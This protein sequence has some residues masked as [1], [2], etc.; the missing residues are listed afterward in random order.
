MI[1]AEFSRTISAS[2]H[3]K[4][5]DGRG[6]PCFSS[7]HVLVC[8][9]EETRWRAKTIDRVENIAFFFFFLI[10]TVRQPTLLCY[11]WIFNAFRGVW[12]L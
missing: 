9:H 3:G 8:L 5:D 2:A 4:N 1:V 7:E 10:I 11:P 12:R 6:S